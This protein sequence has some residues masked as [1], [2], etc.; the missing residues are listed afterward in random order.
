M[1]PDADEFGCRGQGHRATYS[2]S[3]SAS[4]MWLSQFVRVSFADRSTLS[5]GFNHGL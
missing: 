5:R 4:A 3:D 2:R 1:I